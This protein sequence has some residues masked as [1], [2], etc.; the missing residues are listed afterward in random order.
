MVWLLFS[1][2]KTPPPASAVQKSMR[3]RNE[4]LFAIFFF[5]SYSDKCTKWINGSIYLLLYLTLRLAQL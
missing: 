4:N 5:N 1:T 3:K 2:T